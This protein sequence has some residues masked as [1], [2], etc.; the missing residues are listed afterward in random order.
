MKSSD[1]S[2]DPPR[3]TG[4]V[5]FPLGESDGTR[6]ALIRAG[7]E[8]FGRNGFDGTSTRE[9]A[10]AAGVNIA[11][12]A[13]HFG[14]KSGL[15]R[16]CGEAIAAIVI[17]HVATATPPEGDVSALAPEVA[18]DLF[19]A[20]VCGIG[21]FML[22]RPEAEAVAR[23]MVREQMDPSETFATLY[24]RLIRPRHET[25]CRL[26]ARATGERAESTDVIIAVSAMFGQ[27]MFFRVGRATAMARL[28]WET[29]DG[30][31]LEAVL[32]VVTSAIRAT[33]ADRRAAV[34]A[35]NE[36]NP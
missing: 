36:T 21:R 26:F 11:G 2:I 8:L 14:G 30:D 34:S 6:T 16:A 17:E 35:S 4:V 13:Y 27:I 28:G 10:K 9:I 23:F 24:E 25:M 5:P 7:I 20:A 22:G 19:V 29:F 3:P 15:H 1:A 18:A 31:R 32:A 33:I 12:I